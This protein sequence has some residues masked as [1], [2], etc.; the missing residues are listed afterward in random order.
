M[1]QSVFYAS[2]ISRESNSEKVERPR[3]MKCNSGPSRQKEQLRQAAN[4]KE[5]PN[6]PRPTS[7][8]QTVKSGGDTF[9]VQQAQEQEI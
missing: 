2:H 3:G 5:S 1:D 9:S 4:A 8:G 6:H 7:A